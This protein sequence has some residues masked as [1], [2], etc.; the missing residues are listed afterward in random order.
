[1]AVRIGLLVQ[2][3]LLLDLGLASIA[4]V[5]AWRRI[6]DRRHFQALLS[7]K[8]VDHVYM[9]FFPK[10][11]M[12][13]DITLVQFGYLGV[14]LPVVMAS[15]VLLAIPWIRR[16]SGRARLTIAI[17]EAAFV[18]VTVVALNGQAGAGLDPLLV[19][20]AVFI[21]TAVLL[22]A[23]GRYGN[24]VPTAGSAQKRS[25]AADTSPDGWYN[26]PG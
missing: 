24:G 20:V 3:M 1:M 15:V 2:A 18:L 5:Q 10:S 26:L 22:P 11:A 25:K 16:F 14:A 6:D 9:T 8:P 23:R 17:V 21:S 12:H 4:R 13:F 7:D 19:A